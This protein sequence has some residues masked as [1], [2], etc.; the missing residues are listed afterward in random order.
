MDNFI[1]LFEEF[2]L[3]AIELTESALKIDLDEGH[4][5]DSFSA[6]R[7]RLFAIIEQI[8]KQVEWNLISEDKRDELNRQLEYIKRLDE[9]LLTRLQEYREGLK[10][11]IEKTCLQKKNIKRYNLSD[12]K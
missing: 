10:C 12:V 11:E 7:D 6:N 5:L 3:K 2:V 9:K 1:K 4:K 8:S